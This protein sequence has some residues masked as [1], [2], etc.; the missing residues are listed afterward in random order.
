MDIIPEYKKFLKN[1]EILDVK[2]GHTPKNINAFLYDFQKAIVRWSIIRGRSAIFADCGLG[3][4]PMQLNWADDVVRKTDQPVLILAPLA[5]SK[6]TK[7]EGEKFGYSVNICES[8]DDIKP[9]INIT[10]YEKLHK[11]NP[12]VFSGVV[13]D[14]SSILKSYSGKYRNQ[15]IESFQQTPY[16]LAC[17]ATPAPNDYME[18]GNHSE[19]LG[20]MTRSEMLASFFI[21]DASN[22]GTWRLKKHGQSE[23]WKWVCSWAVMLNL[24]SDLGFENNGF[25]I[26]G[27]EIHEHVIKHGK[28]LP[29]QLFVINA[30][31]LSERR[32]ARKETIESRAAIAAKLVNGSDEPW[33]I[34]CNLNNE[35][36]TL[37]RSIHNSV[38]IKGADSTKHKEDS[39]IGFSN[40][41]IKIL[42]TKPKIA[43]FGM[44]WQHCSNVIFMGL[45][46]SY[47]SYYQAVRRCWRFGQKGKVNVHIITADI[48][49]NVVENIKR[50]ER[51]A[52]KMREKMVENMADISSDEIRSLKRDSEKYTTDKTEGDGWTMYLGDSVEVIK[53]I[54]TDAIGYSIFSPPFASL[55][56]YSNSSRDMGNSKNLKSFF[57]HF[58]YLITELYRVTMP[59]RLVSVHCMNLPSLISQDGF[60]GLKDF[61]GDI[62]RYFQDEKFI[63]HS[64]VCIWKD[65]L[66]QAVRTKILT[67]AHKQ[68]VKDSS[69]CAQGIPDFVVT[70]RKPG[71]NQVPISR[72]SG[73]KEYIGDMDIPKAK[74]TADPR[75]NK[76][77]HEIWQRYASPVWFDINQTRVLNSEIARTEKDE[78]HICPL[79]LDTIERCLE[80]WSA[81]GDTVLSPFA[82]IGSEIYCAVKKERYGI[83]IELKR[84]YYAQA[85]KNLGKIKL[86]KKQMEL[87]N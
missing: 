35:S 34:W 38:E 33:L 23:F 86:E 83:G 39:M 25:I 18:L 28:P 42:I 21:N 70:F 76:L 9:G 58:K 43:G 8:K 87:F 17:T 31:T 72:G 81:P 78:K 10:N 47:E 52:L 57:E 85:I 46:D 79:Q 1:K 14:E 15:I 73:F 75:T 49:G 13:L 67:L 77:S 19:F 66:V 26:P 3:K 37:K 11:F 6:Q 69:R 60:L 55:F 2:T 62:I 24:P 44:N 64:E 29:G 45:S 50:K 12:S 48:E 36:D 7:H 20:A 71:L 59:G 5:V 65:P 61:R 53:D 22:T 63:Y 30:S 56:T 54:K 74:Q 4:T 32:Q 84:S 82:G 51:S 27:I 41:S 16:R 68:V 40:E 80:L